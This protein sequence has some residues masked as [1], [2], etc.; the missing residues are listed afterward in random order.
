MPRRRSKNGNGCGDPGPAPWY[1]RPGCT[2]ESR[3]EEVGREYLQRTR[4]VGSMLGTPEAAEGPMTKKTKPCG[5]G[6][7]A[8]V[9]G[10]FAEMSL[11]VGSLPSAIASPPRAVVCACRVQEIDRGPLPHPA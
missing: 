3:Q 1:A 2:A 11:D 6:V 7:V 9:V 8:P 5:P 4:E 10:A